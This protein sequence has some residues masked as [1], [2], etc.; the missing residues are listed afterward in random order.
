MLPE[1]SR[2][3]NHGPGFSGGKTQT[4]SQRVE[5]APRGARDSMHGRKKPDETVRQRL[6]VPEL[7]QT[8]GDSRPP[9][10]H[11]RGT[12]PSRRGCPSGLVSGRYPV[13]DK[14]IKRSYV[15]GNCSG[16][17]FWT[18]V[19]LAADVGSVRSVRM[20]VSGRAPPPSAGYRRIQEGSVSDRRAGAT[21]GTLSRIRV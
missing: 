10:V 21:P 9:A 12:R 2:M 3:V 18:T 14:V 15:L 8:V 16:Q 20:T 5:P 13:V 11:A 17:R 1:G 7:I 19:E 4:A 6:L